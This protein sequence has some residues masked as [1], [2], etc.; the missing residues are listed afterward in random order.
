MHFVRI[1]ITDR[2]LLMDVIIA[3]TFANSH[4]WKEERSDGVTDHQAPD[5]RQIPNR[6]DVAEAPIGRKQPQA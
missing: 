1:S 4:R 3:G 2:I 6:K 5:L